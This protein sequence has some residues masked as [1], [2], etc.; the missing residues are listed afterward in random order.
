MEALSKKTESQQGNTTTKKHVTIFGATITEQI[1]S[2][3]IVLWHAV[4]HMN[5]VYL[6]DSLCWRGVM[7]LLMLV[8]TPATPWEPQVPGFDAFVECC[9]MACVCFNV[10]WKAACV[11]MDNSSKVCFSS[12]YSSDN[13]EGTLC[14]CWSCAPTTPGD[15]LGSSLALKSTQKLR[16]E[17]SLI[18]HHHPH[19]SHFH[20]LF[21]C[22]NR[23]TLPKRFRKPIFVEK[24]KK[25]P[26][27]RLGTLTQSHREKTS[28]PLARPRYSMDWIL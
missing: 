19:P 26:G 6:D 17:S 24:T 7:N 4:A 12:I 3:A 11:I 2:C 28:H 9:W 27:L 21:I 25:T 5:S 8:A 13:F 22:Y 16:M 20:H 1:V 15:F 14:F 23:W 18:P 10:D